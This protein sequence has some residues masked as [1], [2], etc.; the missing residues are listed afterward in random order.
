M[1]TRLN[2]ALI[3]LRRRA[4]LLHLLVERVRV[5]SLERE[6]AAEPGEVTLGEG[7]ADDIITGGGHRNHRNMTIYLTRE[8]GR[9]G[10]REGGGR[11]TR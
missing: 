1:Y 8:K 2:H 10:G 11:V 7:G 9:E 5:K 6:V 3:H 4:D